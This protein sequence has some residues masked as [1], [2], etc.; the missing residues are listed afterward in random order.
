MSNN[1]HELFQ[2]SLNERITKQLRLLDSESGP[3]ADFAKDVKVVN[4]KV[5]RPQYPDYATHQPDISFWHRKS[6]LPT[7][8]IETAHA[9]Q[10]CKPEALA[11]DYILGSDLVVS[12]RDFKRH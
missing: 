6:A 7:V 5:I 4:R 3:A 9:H 8:I 10:G 2:G 12:H 1:V 11:E